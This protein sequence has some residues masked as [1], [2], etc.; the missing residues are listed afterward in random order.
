MGEAKKSMHMFDMMVNDPLSL[1]GR[2]TMLNVDQHYNHDNLH[3]R[4]KG[5]EVGEFQTAFHVCQWT[6]KS[7]LIE[8]LKCLESRVWTDG[9]VKVVAAPTGLAASTSCFSFPLSMRVRLPTTGHSQKVLKTKLRD[10]K[11]I[12]ADEISMVSS[13]NFAYMHL[14]LEELF[15][16]GD[17]SRCRNVMFVGYILQLQPLVGIPCLRILQRSDTKQIRLLLP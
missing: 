6:G 12:I 15:G 9:G 2:E 13:L 16:G 1:E 14:R 8:A 5:H 3:T 11:L 4:Q 10:V 17:W 7:F